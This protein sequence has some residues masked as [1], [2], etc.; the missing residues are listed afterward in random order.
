MTSKNKVKYRGS[1]LLNTVL[2]AAAALAAEVALL[3]NSKLADVILCQFG[4]QGS[5]ASLSGEYNAPLI[6]CL[7]ADWHMRVCFLCLVCFSIEHS[8]IQERFQHLFRRFQKD[9]LIRVS[10][11]RR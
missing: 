11:A 9:I 10:S 2:S 7:S 5:V 3:L 8:N 4:F 6:F 1:L